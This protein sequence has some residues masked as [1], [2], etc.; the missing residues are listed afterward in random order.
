MYRRAHLIVRESQVE[1]F[2]FIPVIESCLS[3]PQ[4]IHFI[5]FQ[6][7]DVNIYEFKDHV[8]ICR[9]CVVMPNVEEEQ[10]MRATHVMN[11]IVEH[12]SEV[13]QH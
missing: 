3:P 11:S 8:Q 6:L 1:V 9:P 5:S 12:L 10:T 7:F 13:F 4:S 2:L